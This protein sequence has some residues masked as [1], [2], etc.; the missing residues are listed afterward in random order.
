MTA[1][2]RYNNV[3]LDGKPMKIEIVGFNVA[4]SA[5]VLSNIPRGM[6]NWAPRRYFYIN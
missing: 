5:P 4:V 3:R 1:V 2:K 6:T